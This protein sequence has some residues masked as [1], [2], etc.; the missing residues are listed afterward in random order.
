MFQNYLTTVTWDT[1]LRNLG[2]LKDSGLVSCGQKI[3]SGAPAATA[4]KFIAGAIIQNTATGIVYINAGTTAS[5][6]WE[7]IEAGTI[8]LANARIL[9]G[10]ISGI[11]TAVAMSGDATIANTGAVT[12][13][14]DAITTAKI[15]AG[16]VT[17]A[18]LDS[19]IT[20][21]HVIKFAGNHTTVGGSTT[22]TINVPGCL[23][24]DLTFIQMVNDGTNNASVVFVNT[25]IG[26]I[27]V[28]FSADPGNDAVISYQIIRAAA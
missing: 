2:I 1:T 27:D 13:A 17:L 9:V 3:T 18:K 7:A 16:Q 19:G 11:A 26:S 24:T 8:A 10:N 20:P 22:E 25:N 12:I 15:A 23:A 28:E 5:P 6:S 4:G 14:N 21:S